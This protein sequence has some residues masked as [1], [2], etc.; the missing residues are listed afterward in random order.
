MGSLRSPPDK[1]VKTWKTSEYSNPANTYMP[2]YAAMPDERQKCTNEDMAE[3]IALRVRVAT[4]LRNK[5]VSITY[6]ADIICQNC[7]DFFY[8][9]VLDI[10]LTLTID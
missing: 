7:P 6:K 3:R 2:A 1:D 10:F 9:I 5:Y 4:F 8:F